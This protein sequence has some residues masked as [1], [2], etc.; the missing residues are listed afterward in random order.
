MTETPELD[1]QSELFKDG[2]I[3]ALQEFQEWLDAQG[4]SLMRWEEVFEDQDCVKCGGLGHKLRKNDHP[5]AGWSADQPAEFK[6]P[7]K[8][9]DG[10]GMN[11]V[12]V[13]EGW[14]PDGRTRKKLLAD[15]LGLDLDQIEQEQFALLAAQRE[16]NDRT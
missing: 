1:R 15:H 11:S 12:K 13:S 2:T 4:L 6:I 14:V 9:C 8:K 5:Y 10:G 3:P 16:L 7:C